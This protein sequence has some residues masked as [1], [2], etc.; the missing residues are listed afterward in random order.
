MNL[1]I[2]GS[3]NARFWAAGAWLLTMMSAASAQSV[4][5]IANLKG[6]AREQ[7]LVD[8]AKKEGKVVIY[9]AMIEPT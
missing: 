5:E 1:M 2:L 4:A 6:P 3:G 9:S 7:T 8:G